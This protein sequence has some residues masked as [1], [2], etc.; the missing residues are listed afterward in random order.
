MTLTGRVNPGSTSLISALRR[1]ARTLAAFAAGVLCV[2]NAASA[3]E[4]RRFA[5]VIGSN[6]GGPEREAL[7]YARDDAQAMLGVLEELG[8]VRPTDATYLE[9]PTWMELDVAMSAVGREVRDAR[10][11]GARVELVLYYSGHSDETGLM[12][13]GSLLTYTNLR[14]SL[15]TIPADVRITILDSCASGA[16]LR[17][18]GGTRTP[19]FLVDRANTVTGEAY[20]TSSTAVESSQESDRI[21]ASFF[22]W[23]LVAGLRGAADEDGDGLVTLSEAYGY[24]FRETRRSTEDTLAG[25]QHPN[26]ALDLAGQ[27]D[28][29]MTDLRSATAML[30]F[31]PGLDGRLWVADADGDL[32]A[33]LEKVVG[34][35]IDLSVPPGPYRVTLQARPTRWVTDV[36]V[37]AGGSASVSSADFSADNALIATRLRGTAPPVLAA[38]EH[39]RPFGLQVVHGVGYGGPTTA[40]HGFALDVLQGTWHEVDGGELSFLV[41][42]SL[43]GVRGAQVSLIGALAGGDVHGAQLGSVF[44]VTRGSFTGFQGAAVVSSAKD[45]DRGL[46]ASGLVN[47]ATGDA[48]AGTFSAQLTMGVNVAGGSRKGAQ[49]A[50]LVNVQGGNLS[51]AQ[52]AGLVNTSGG[53]MRGLQASMLGNVSGGAMAGLQISGLFNAAHRFDGAQ[54]SLINT[55]AGHGV[56]VGAVN[57]ATSLRG[58]QVGLV[59]VARHLDGEAI[60]LLSF[61][62][63]GYHAWEVFSDDVSPVATSFKF[64]SRRLY[65]VWQLGFDPT[66]HNRL[67]VAAGLGVHAEMSRLWFDGDVMFGTPDIGG[68]SNPVPG[69]RVILRPTLGVRLIGKTGLFF[70]PSVQWLAPLGDGP[71]SSPT[72]MPTWRT[73]DGLS[74]IGYSAGFRVGF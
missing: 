60:G 51:G 9:D 71:L 38:A 46:Q 70:G 6:D 11:A 49:L 16:V 15:A 33:E 14:R 72:L 58:A 65:S 47:I 37:P 1:S 63:N 4:L 2:A 21:G 55:G 57:V 20:L 53:S 22:T 50:G 24:T 43:H 8:G 29:V 56:Q 45:F 40:V 35:P 13:G 73:G 74:W 19:P 36:Q 42:S 59:N 26:Y 61:I 54:L 31:D 62:G 27:G 41:G 66:N 44:A 32:F 39:T 52:L 34:V 48:P 68:S 5:L 12:L 3:A 23:H 67:S 69:L 17:T 7:L 28:F 10:R 30:H 25:P 64:G 18:K